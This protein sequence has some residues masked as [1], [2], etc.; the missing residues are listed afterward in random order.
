MERRK[1]D[2]E[3]PSRF[4]GFLKAQK[5]LFTVGDSNKGVVTCIPGQTK[6]GEEKE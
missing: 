3:I 5:P 2:Y 6:K 4:R 1:W